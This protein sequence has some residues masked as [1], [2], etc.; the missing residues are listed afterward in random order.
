MQMARISSVRAFPSAVFSGFI[1]V[2][3]LARADLR[4]ADSPIHACTSFGELGD[5]RVLPPVSAVSWASARIPSRSRRAFWYGVKNDR[6]PV[7]RNP[8]LPVSRSL[9]KPQEHLR[10]VRELQVVLHQPLELRL[11]LR[12][13]LRGTEEP[14]PSTPTTSSELRRI[15]QNRALERSRTL[16]RASHT[17]GPLPNSAR[18]HDV[19]SPAQAPAHDSPNAMGEKANANTSATGA[20]RPSTP[21]TP[22]MASAA[23]SAGSSKVGTLDARATRKPLTGNAA[24]TPTAEQRQRRSGGC[25]V[26]IDHREVD[27]HPVTDRDGRGETGDHRP[28]RY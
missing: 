4:L 26:L 28:D 15:R 12:V 9:V 16:G 14:E 25:V 7:R 10:I 17:A 2:P 8:R 22:A 27:V 13:R 21:Q 5:A 18:A 6:S 3:S 20:M 23:P 24:S 11:E 19:A 1:S